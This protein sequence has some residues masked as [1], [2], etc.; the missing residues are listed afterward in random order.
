MKNGVHFERVRI[1]ALE[2][3]D[4]PLR[5]TSAELSQRMAPMLRRF[6]MPLD[7]LESLTGIVARRQW[8]PGTTPSTVATEAGA[9]AI[10][11]AGIDRARIGLVVNS[12]VCKDFIEPSVASTVHG[13]LGLSADCL[14]FDVGNACLAF[15][16]AMTIAGN[17]IERGQIDCALIVDGE[18]S[19]QITDATIQ[20]LL[21]PASTPR[22]LRDNFASLTLG[23]G[24]VAMVL[25]DVDVFPHGHRLLG[26]VTV[27]ASE[28]NHLCRGHAEE[29][30][31][32]GAGLLSAGLSLAERTFARAGQVLGW[33]PD[34]L[35]E[36]VLHQVSAV[37][38]QKLLDKLGIAQSKAHT[39]FHEHGNVG[40]AALPITLAKAAAAGRIARGHRVGLMGIGSGLNCAMMEVVW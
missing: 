37:H 39:I 26:G 9:R 19:R 23:S 30:I 15:L 21:D 27:A 17:M 29:M 20:R 5:V 1:G 24:A 40:P 3:L 22:T 28:H 11:A 4:P 8:S 7:M 36:C 35:D 38:T 2:C 13:Q 12:S 18:G 6:G 33:T 10:A 25:G 32:D 16:D 31:T 14:S 34:A